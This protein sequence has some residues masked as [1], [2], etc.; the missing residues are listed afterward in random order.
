MSKG[1]RRERQAAKLYEA[2]GYQVETPV[3][4]KWDTNTDFFNLFDGMASDGGWLRFYQVKSNRAVG[5]ND[6]FEDAAETVPKFAVIDYLVCHDREGWR[7][8]EVRQNGY[9]W[10]VDERDMD[11]KM[12]EGVTDYLNGGGE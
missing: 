5:I 10:V 12:G 11:C 3:E 4:T 9:E 8:A 1:K 2:A 7:F 6:Y